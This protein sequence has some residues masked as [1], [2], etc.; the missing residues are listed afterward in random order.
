MAAADPAHAPVISMPLINKILWRVVSS[1]LGLNITFVRGV[2]S[3]DGSNRR[4]NIRRVR[5]SSGIT[6]MTDVGPW[7][8]RRIR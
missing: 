4:L 5:F 1:A 3:I 8:I 6:S 7:S 2:A